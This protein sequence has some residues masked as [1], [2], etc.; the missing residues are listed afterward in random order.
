MQLCRERAIPVTLTALHALTP[1]ETA[2]ESVLTDAQQEALELACERGYFESPRQVTME[3]L[4]EELDILQTS[5]PSEGSA[6]TDGPVALLPT[7]DLPEL[8]T[9]TYHIERDDEQGTPLC[10]CS[11]DTDYT[12][13][14]FEDVET[15]SA[16]CCQICL[17]VYQNGHEISP[18]I[19][20][21][22]HHAQIGT[23][24][25]PNNVVSTDTQRATSPITRT[26]V[27]AQTHSQE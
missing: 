23:T 15:D 6:N 12:C 2:T 9:T 25:P 14:A 26:S 8:T 18:P 17:T 4:G 11:P 3:D 27:H 1:I 10:N 21:D 5:A 19:I 13:I 24:E 7:V 16:R 22:A 20:R